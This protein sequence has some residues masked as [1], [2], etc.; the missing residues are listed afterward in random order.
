MLR[1][2]VISRLGIRNILRRKGYDAVVVATGAVGS[3][4]LFVVGEDLEGIMPGL[5]FL[6]QVCDKKI[7]SLKGKIGIVGGGNTAVDVARV[8]KRLGAD[9]VKILY[10][11][12]RKEMPA[13]QEEID[14]AIEEGIEIVPQVQVSKFIGKNGK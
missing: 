7:T 4:E 13:Y 1:N 8:A 12:S 14:D 9:H 5:E 3:Y 11:R 6:K 10:R 2:R